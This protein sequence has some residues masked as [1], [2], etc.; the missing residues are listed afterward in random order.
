MNG[1]IEF[2]F[3]IHDNVLRITTKLFPP[4]SLYPILNLWIASKFNLSTISFKKGETVHV[5]F[6]IFNGDFESLYKNY[7]IFFGPRVLEY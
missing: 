1:N 2:Q 6:T 3:H 4:T 5:L 7:G